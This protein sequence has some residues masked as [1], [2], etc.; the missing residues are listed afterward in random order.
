MSQMDDRDVRILLGRCA[1]IRAVPDDPGPEFPRVPF[2]CA[3]WPARCHLC[4][5]VECTRV[6]DPRG[7]PGGAA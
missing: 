5:V 4:A 2:A 1:G 7:E 6:V 3:E